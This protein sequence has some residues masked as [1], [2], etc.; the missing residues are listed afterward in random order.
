VLWPGREQELAQGQVQAPG[1]A[2]V[3]EPVW[4]LAPALELAPVP[5]WVEAQELAAAARLA[6]AS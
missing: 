1:L 4:A 3:R 5:G 6:A 2:L